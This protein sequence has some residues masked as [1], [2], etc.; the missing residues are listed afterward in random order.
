MSADND[1]ACAKLEGTTEEG[2]F[3]VNY[4]AAI[5]NVSSLRLR[6]RVEGASAILSVRA[7]AADGAPAAQKPTSP[8]SLKKAPGKGKHVA[9]SAGRHDGAA[10]TSSP[11]TQERVQVVLAEGADD[12]LQLEV[13]AVMDG[14]AVLVVSAYALEMPTVAS[15]GRFSTNRGVEIASCQ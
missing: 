14:D 1:D 3:V 11:D 6:R 7:D 8:M 5:V 13:V 15:S 9:E 2:V 12:A 10:N 4:D